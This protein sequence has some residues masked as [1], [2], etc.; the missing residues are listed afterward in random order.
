MRRANRRLEYGD[1]SDPRIRA[2]L[3]HIS[4][5]NNADKIGVPLFVTH[6]EMDTRV[7]VHEAVSMYRIV[8]GK[9]GGRAQLVI[10]EGEGHGK[11]QYVSGAPPFC[12][13]QIRV[14]AK[15][16]D[17]MGERC[18]SRLFQEV[19][20][21][22]VDFLFAGVF[23][24]VFL[25]WVTESLGQETERRN[26]TASICIQLDAAAPWVYPTQNKAFSIIPHRHCRMHQAYVNIRHHLYPRSLLCSFNPSRFPKRFRIGAEGIQ[27][28]VNSAAA[29]L[30]YTTLVGFQ[31][32]E[33]LE[34][35]GLP[36]LKFGRPGGVPP[37]SQETTLSE[38]PAICS[39]SRSH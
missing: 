32:N 26:A 11:A 39:G 37:T 2:F 34:W 16:C 3:E 19:L 8:Q 7:T 22:I 38:L 35:L 30:S 5:L 14:Q 18:Y 9:P 12:L 21:I 31:L 20:A 29:A 24:G 33:G 15:E 6:G 10:C 27:A 28:A 17:R 13:M 4:P 1:E 36:Q 23:T 25:P